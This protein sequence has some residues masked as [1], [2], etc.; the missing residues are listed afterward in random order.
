M[1]GRGRPVGLRLCGV[2]S[3]SA[4][5]RDTASHLG[6][7]VRRLPVAGLLDLHRLQP[8]RHLRVKRWA[9]LL[10]TVEAIVSLGIFG[11]VI[12]RAINILK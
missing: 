8:H 10:M 9:K 1:K 12:A 3:G 6:A 2:F 7:H 11:L 4:G 5:A